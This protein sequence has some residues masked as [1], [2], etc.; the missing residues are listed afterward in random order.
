MNNLGF[1]ILPPTLPP[2]FFFYS[3]KYLILF[4]MASFFFSCQWSKALKYFTNK[5]DFGGKI[6]KENTLK[7]ARDDK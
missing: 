6:K 3:N 5:G 1:F 7:M 4:K 2:H